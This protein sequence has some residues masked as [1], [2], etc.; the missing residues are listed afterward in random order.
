MN[1]TVNQEQA[2]VDQQEAKTFT[3][4]E[5]NTIVGERLKRER[6]KFADYEDLKAK[7]GRLDE[8][9]EANK[10]EL[11][12]ATERAQALEAELNSLK[13][14]ETIR[15]LRDK[16][17]TETGVPASLLT[18]KTEDEC[19]EQANA[20]LGFARPQE[21]PQ[22]KDGGEVNHVGKPTSKQQFAEWANQAFNS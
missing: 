10:T 22:V 6:E 19:R 14:A 2:T 20:I 16:V 7:A 13:E 5:L 15:T 12:K 17:A 18:A 11:Q 3:Q 21:Y 1:E 9:E 8:L 4:D